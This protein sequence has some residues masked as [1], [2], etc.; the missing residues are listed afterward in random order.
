[1]RR[2]ATFLALTA[3]AATVA[4]GSGKPKTPAAA[5]CP[6]TGAISDGESLPDCTFKGLL[7]WPDL[8]LDALKGTPSV[9]NFW[10]SWCNACIA[11]M[12]SFDRIAKSFGARLVVV[13]FN[14]LGVLNET[15]ADAERFARKTGAGY[16]LASDP[17]GTLYGH[18][19]TPL[20]PTLPITVFVDANGVVRARHIGQM[21]EKDLRAQLASA[22]H[23][24]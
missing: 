21:D 22:L 12:P 4:C 24:D 8:R 18:F 6:F 14:E 16:R 9:L 7:S 2:L 13:G 23:L 3:L 10:A 5:P 19:F 1:M 17:N 11:E 15:A 20:R